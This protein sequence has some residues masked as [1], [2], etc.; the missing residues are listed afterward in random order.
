MSILNTRAWTS[1]RKEHD[2]VEVDTCD[3]TLLRSFQ[4]LS[5]LNARLR[6]PRDLVGA[7]ATLD[8]YLTSEGS[9]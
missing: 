9:P 4:L 2:D 8:E 1:R 7:E 5:A 6:G 3:A